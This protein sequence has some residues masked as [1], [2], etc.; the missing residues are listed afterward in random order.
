M[1]SA[2]KC[3]P[4]P[5]VWCAGAYLSRVITRVH[6]DLMT[7]AHRVTP[8]QPDRAAPSELLRRARESLLIAGGFLGTGRHRSRQLDRLLE[9][10]INAWTFSHMRWLRP[11]E[12]VRAAA[13][14]RPLPKRHRPLKVRYEL[15]GT[16]FGLSDLHRRTETTAFVVLHRGAVVHE[17]Y[18]GR[19][20]GGSRRFLLFSLTKSMLSVLVGIAVDEGAIDDLQTPVVSYL[21]QLRGTAYDGPSVLDLLNMSSGVGD[22]EDWADP[23][24]TIIRLK[25]AV[26]GDGTLTDLVTSVQSGTTPGTAFNYSS[27]DAQVLGWVLEAATGTALPRYAAQRLWSRLGA[28]H[29]GFFWLSWTRPRT[30]IGAG[31]FNATPR[32]LARLG[33]LMTRQ[34]TVGDEHIVSSEWVARCRAGDRPHLAVGALGP[35]GY[36]HYG[37]SRLWWTV[38]GPRRPVTGL[39]IYGQYLYVD[40]EADV[41][42]VKSSAWPTPDDPDRD[43]ETITALQ[44][45]ADYL[46]AEETR[47]PEA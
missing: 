24:S 15:D 36:P 9:P 6:A 11:V 16:S 27:L 12:R 31:S 40:T 10:W 19:F 17:Q 37:Y 5:P 29:D 18:P 7:E 13:H 30:A 22:L 39:G 2:R 38:D 25:K 14:P 4:E 23:E 8:P 20:A 1:N 3:V 41:V 35:S 45:V 47:T 28:E 42:I 21:P 43:R 33:L 32:D 44:A 26:N 46:A 34:G